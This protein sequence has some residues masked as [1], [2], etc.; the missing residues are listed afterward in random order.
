MVKLAQAATP[1]GT[2]AGDRFTMPG[3]SP[4]D[5]GSCAPAS[6]SFTLVDGPLETG[7]PAPVLGGESG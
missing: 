3:P 6:T 5:P 7:I 4:P 2:V 1:M